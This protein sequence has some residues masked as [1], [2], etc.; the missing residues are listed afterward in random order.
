MAIDSLLGVFSGWAIPDRIGH[1]GSTQACVDWYPPV[2]LHP[3]EDSTRELVSLD[4]RR[5]YTP[6]LTRW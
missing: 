6:V 5:A 1:S 3:S 4:W 2:D